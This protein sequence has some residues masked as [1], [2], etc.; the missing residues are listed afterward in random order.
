MTSIRSPDHPLPSRHCTGSSLRSVNR[1]HGK[2]HIPRALRFSY[3]LLEVFVSGFFFVRVAR[4]F[5]RFRGHDAATRRHVPTRVYITVRIVLVIDFSKVRGSALLIPYK[6]DDNF[7]PAAV[8]REGRPNR[9]SF[10][11][12]GTASCRPKF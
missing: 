6:R 8:G 3:T 5:V 10:R 7:A 9:T 1:A 4:A 12:T 2:Y 11:V